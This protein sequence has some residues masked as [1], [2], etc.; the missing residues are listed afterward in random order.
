MSE[1]TKED[2]LIEKVREFKW[3]DIDNEETDGELLVVLE[4]EIK[5]CVSALSAHLM[6][7]ISGEYFGNI[8]T[9]GM[10]FVIPVGLELHPLMRKRFEEKWDLN[11]RLDMFQSIR[12]SLTAEFTNNEKR[13]ALDAKIQAAL[14]ATHRKKFISGEVSLE[15]DAMVIGDDSNMVSIEIP[16][17]ISQQGNLR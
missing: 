15:D 14:P 7:H 12:E 2:K 11:S 17:I 1:K 6:S 5:E 8:D 3:D 10:Q 4:E 16:L 13:D 9:S